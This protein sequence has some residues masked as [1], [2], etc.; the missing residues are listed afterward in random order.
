[1]KWSS[2]VA[3]R[4]GKENLDDEVA[5]L[6]PG[7]YDRYSA[8]VVNDGLDLMNVPLNLID[9]ALSLKAVR[10]NGRALLLVPEVF[11]DDE[12]YLEA[13]KQNGWVILWVPTDRITREMVVEAMCGHGVTR[14]AIDA[15]ASFAKSKPSGVELE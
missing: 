9:R 3:V 6:S 7:S 5:L 13:V 1:M 2:E 8:A 10:Q 4:E 12:I 14:M 11:L 15:W